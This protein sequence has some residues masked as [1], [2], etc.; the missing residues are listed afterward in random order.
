MI[1]LINLVNII[2][3]Q[4]L[5]IYPPLY[6]EVNEPKTTKVINVVNG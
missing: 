3:E 5:K 6:F 4:K 2:G 1:E